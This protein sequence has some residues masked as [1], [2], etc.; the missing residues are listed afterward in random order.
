VGGL[1]KFC[2]FLSSR[3]LPFDSVD[4]LLIMYESKAFLPGG[5]SPE[6]A[7]QGA[8]LDRMDTT[9]NTSKWNPLGWQK[10]WKLTAIM[11]AIVVLII[12]IVAAVEGSKNS[13]SKDSYPNYHPLN[14]TL[15]DRWQ[16]T[17]FFDNFDYHSSADPANGFVKFVTFGKG[18]GVVD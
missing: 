7:Y 15:E 5:T 11:A 17:T 18:S 16:G 9:L 12:I 13:K 2:C 10:K 8:R 3:R 6:T 14:Y 4:L 1:Y